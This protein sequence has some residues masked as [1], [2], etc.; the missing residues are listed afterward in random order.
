[1]TSDHLEIGVDQN[2]IVELEALDAVCDLPDVLSAMQPR[3]SGV[4]FQFSDGSKTISIRLA[5]GGSLPVR[6][7]ALCIIDIL[8]NLYILPQ[9][10]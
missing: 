7:L 3:V 4:E 5:G 6:F 1:M 10:N 2:W 9:Q 8:C